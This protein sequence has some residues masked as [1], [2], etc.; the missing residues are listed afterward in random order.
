[1]RA[2]GWMCAAGAIAL[3]AAAAGA[4]SPSNW[5][6]WVEGDPPDWDGIV[7][8]SQQTTL[9]CDK[10]VIRLI[11][12]D[13]AN[14]SGTDFKLGP[15]MT[16][17]VLACIKQL[18][19]GGFTGE[20]GMLPY[21][22]GNWVWTPE[23]VTVGSEWE[24]PFY[25]AKQA[26]E[27]LATA[28]V[29][30]GIFEVNFENENSGG[31]LEVSDASLLAVQTFQST[32]WPQLSQSSG[33]IGLAA[34]K[35]YTSAINM[36]RWTTTP[37]LGGSFAEPPLAS[38]MLELYNMYK[39][40]PGGSDCET[41]FVDAYSTPPQ[42]PNP[43]PASPTTIYT[44]A[45]A[46]A[47]P[48]TDIL[49]TAT[50]ECP[51]QADFGFLFGNKTPPCTG[52][53]APPDCMTGADMSRVWMLFSTETTSLGTID[54]FG[55]WSAEP[56]SGASV[57]TFKSFCVAFED[58]FYTQYWNAGSPGGSA[59][60]PRYGVFHLE[61]LP[62]TWKPNL[63]GPEPCEGD[64]SGDDL[65]DLTDILMVLDNWGTPAG[66]VN[67]DGLTDV[68]DLLVVLGSFGGC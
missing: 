18:R 50:A 11:D 57:E 2:T 34:T 16:A 49:G 66:D 67:D 25:W 27:I 65:V 12:P 55:T 14:G 7:Q 10:L 53:Y 4:D 3:M 39:C 23:G 40:C 37:L 45:A 36:L 60:P 47:D 46:A 32:Q 64:L 63:G 6:M 30:P 19:D 48:V 62:N 44:R 68:S 42:T 51:T 52:P 38:G 1:M 54:A 15:G 8:W 26:N 20:I 58:A 29:T 9:P 28:G 56:G 13:A 17:P 31:I 41:T 59:K 43:S 61:Y 24:K 21:F 5:M 22:D 35:G 33:F